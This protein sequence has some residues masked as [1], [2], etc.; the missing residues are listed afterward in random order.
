MAYW[1]HTH[2]APNIRVSF[3]IPVSKGG[4]RFI[5]KLFFRESCLPT[6]IYFLRRTVMFIKMKES[7]GFTLVELMI[8]VAIIGILAAV[9][10][11]FYQRYIAKARLTSYVWPGVHA[12]ET[13][14]GSYYSFNTALPT[15]AATFQAFLA[16]SDS[17]CFNV[18]IPTSATDSWSITVTTSKDS[19]VG[20]TCSKLL[21][22]QGPTTGRMTF[23]PKTAAGKI[24]SWT[25]GQT[26]LAI[27]LGLAGG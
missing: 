19:A 1:L 16:D 12:V 8:V 20:R 9:A 5:E 13:N 2:K 25:V 15:T 26:T 18:A 11:P 21:S 7:K 4:M 22:L 17:S 3:P 27:N 6:L 10:V 24:V 23:T 14:V